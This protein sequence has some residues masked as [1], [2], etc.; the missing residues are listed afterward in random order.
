M[1]YEFDSV[2]GISRIIRFLKGN[3]NKSLFNIHCS[4]SCLSCLCTSWCFRIRYC[5]LLLRA[6][7]MLRVCYSCNISWVTGA[8]RTSILL[9]LLLEVIRTFIWQHIASNNLQQKNDKYIQAR[10]VSL[11]ERRNFPTTLRARRQ[12]HY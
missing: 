7:L 2:A 1:P 3:S 4:Q 12:Q 5:S 6:N 9:N 10:S 8:S 11:R